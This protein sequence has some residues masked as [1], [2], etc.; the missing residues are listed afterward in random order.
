MIGNRGITLRGKV[1]Q[2]QREQTVSAEEVEKWKIQVKNL[3]GLNDRSSFG[4][5]AQEKKV[6]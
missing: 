4:E 2:D 6:I 5:V 1:A 3:E